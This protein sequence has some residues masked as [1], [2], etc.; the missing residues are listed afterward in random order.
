[1]S[2]DKNLSNNNIILKKIVIDNY[3]NFNHIEIKFKSNI[4]IIY[5]QSGTG[6]STILDAI[7]NI[8]KKIINKDD[9]PYNLLFFAENPISIRY[10]LNSD[11]FMDNDLNQDVIISLM[12]NSINVDENPLNSTLT[13][14]KLIKIIDGRLKI[15]IINQFRYYKFKDKSARLKS[16]G[17]RYFDFI[18]QELEKCMP[19]RNS[20]ILVDDFNAYFDYYKEEKI[21]QKLQLV[22]IHNQ[23]IITTPIIH[24]ESILNSKKYEIHELA[25]FN[26]YY[27]NSLV[28]NTDFFTTFTTESKIV[29][30]ILDFNVENDKI[31]NSVLKMS[32][33][34]LITILEAYLSDSL[35][36]TIR[37]NKNFLRRLVETTPQFEKEKFSLSDIFRKFDSIEENMIKYLSDLIYHDIAKIQHIYKDV[38]DVDFPENLDDIY[39]AINTRH[40]LVHRNGKMKDGKMIILSNE[41]LYFL[42]EILTNFIQFLDNQINRI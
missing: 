17:E 40:D 42:M 1:M 38:L 32:F 29:K 21:I 30:D 13:N 5:G 26:L 10:Y 11:Y 37:K 39:R 4:S 23:I 20:I 31:K 9:I 25:P 24:N 35:I 34:H 28:S 33:I 3:K 19:F 6:K 7:Q 12:N 16:Q 27:L 22:A 2:I 14:R 36:N 18:I 8:K 41:D 15:Y